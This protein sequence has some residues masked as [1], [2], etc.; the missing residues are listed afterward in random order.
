VNLNSVTVVEPQ[1]WI[2][3]FTRQAHSRLFSFIAFG[4]LKHVLA[5]SWVPAINAWLVYDPGYWNTR[6][7]A[8][9]GTP[10]GNAEIAS[11]CRG[12]VVVSMP[13]RDGRAR[14]LRAGVF[15]TSAIKHLVGMT[16]GALRP[17]AMFRHCLAQGGAVIDGDQEGA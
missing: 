15:C 2:V 4:R 12:N 11:L 14:L 16:G 3:V 17:D 13:R 1:R 10:E 6:V 5:L 8:V 7:Y 9:L